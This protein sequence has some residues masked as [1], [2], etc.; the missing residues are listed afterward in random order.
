VGDDLFGAP[1]AEPLTL[2]GGFVCGDL[3]P[4][5]WHVATGAKR[6]RIE[7][8]FYN[9]AEARWFVATVWLDIQDPG[10]EYADAGGEIIRDI[11]KH[12]R[13]WLLRV[14]P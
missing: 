14:Q 10:D 11:P 4:I 13:W 9:P 2:Q 7:V 6:D 1:G 8:L 12:W 3:D 5:D